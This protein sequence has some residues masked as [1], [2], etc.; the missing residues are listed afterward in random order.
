MLISHAQNFEEIQV[1][2]KDHSF[3]DYI[4][5]HKFHITEIDCKGLDIRNN[6]NKHPN[7]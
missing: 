7:T 1:N 2:Q 4:F 6:N 3:T 5:Q